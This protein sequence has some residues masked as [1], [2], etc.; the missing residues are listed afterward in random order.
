MTKTPNASNFNEYFNF[1]FEQYLQELLLCYTNE[2]QR[3][4][5]NTSPER[6]K[7]FTS[8]AM[9]EFRANRMKMLK[10]RWESI[11]RHQLPGK[12]TAAA[13]ITKICEEI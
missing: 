3:E 7:L 10:I 6:A 12:N 4:M 1:K 5:I 11:Q 8:W 2:K 9:S 13:M